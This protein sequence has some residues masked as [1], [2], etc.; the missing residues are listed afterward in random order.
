[1]SKSKENSKSLQLRFDQNQVVGDHNSVPNALDVSNTH[2]GVI[3]SWIN[4][5]EAG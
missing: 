1:M 4:L 2:A 5:T 3:L